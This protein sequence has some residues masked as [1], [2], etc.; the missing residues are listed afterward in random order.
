MAEVHTKQKTQFRGIDIPSDPRILDLFKIIGELSKNSKN[1][2]NI[3]YNLQNLVKNSKETKIS[4]I[5]DKW[6][7]S[8]LNSLVKKITEE[9]ENLHPHLAIRELRNFWLN[10]F[11]RGYIQFVRDRLAA[12]NKEAKFV[13][14]EV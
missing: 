14:K 11:S 13:V 4:R 5:E 12:E 7:M 8:R 3:F 10:D 6:I 2:L 9:L 1:N